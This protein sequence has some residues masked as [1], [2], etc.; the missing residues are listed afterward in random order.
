[1][2]PDRVGDRERTTDEEVGTEDSGFMLPFSPRVEKKEEDE[3]DGMIRWDREPGIGL[4]IRS[5]SCVRSS[6]LLAI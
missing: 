4:V 1:M 5:V 3:E 6:D 2:S